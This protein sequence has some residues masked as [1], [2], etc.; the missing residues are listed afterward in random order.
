MMELIQSRFLLNPF[1]LGKFRA[2]GAKSTL[3]MLQT[4]HNH[5]IISQDHVFNKLH[6]N[7]YDVIVI[8]IFSITT[9]GTKDCLS[10][11]RICRLKFYVETFR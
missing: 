9:V 4:Y 1:G 3:R 8:I 5:V 2:F 7:N 6:N 11:V 10:P